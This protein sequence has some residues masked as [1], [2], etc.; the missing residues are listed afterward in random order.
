LGWI[1]IVVNLFG[2]EEIEAGQTGFDTAFMEQVRMPPA[3]RDGV[4]MD[5]YTCGRSGAQGLFRDPL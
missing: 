3:M 1:D 4:S 5:S 2:P